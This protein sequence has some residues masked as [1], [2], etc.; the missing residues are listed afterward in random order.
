[1]A[2]DEVRIGAIVE[3]RGSLLPAW[4][5]YEVEQVPALPIGRGYV[6]RAIH[7][8]HDDDVLRNVH[9]D[10]F[11][12]YEEPDASMICAVDDDVW[13]YLLG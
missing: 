1:M 10:S 11:D 6:L 7:A 5:V 13:K 8:R 12:V 9:R 4:G 2:N 3:Y